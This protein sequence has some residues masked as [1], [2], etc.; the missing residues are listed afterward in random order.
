[1]NNNTSLEFE[2]YDFPPELKKRVLQELLTTI[3]HPKSLQSIGENMIDRLK[4][5]SER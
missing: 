3:L 4:Q 5:K 2:D 1:M